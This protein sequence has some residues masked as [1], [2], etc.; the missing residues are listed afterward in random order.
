MFFFFLFL[1]SFDIE[2]LTVFIWYTHTQ[3]FM[4]QR[5]LLSAL[6]CMH[7]QSSACQWVSLVSF[8]VCSTWKSNIWLWFSAHKARPVKWMRMGL[9]SFTE[10]PP[11]T[12]TW[13]ESFVNKWV[14]GCYLAHNPISAMYQLEF[15]STCWSQVD[16]CFKLSNGLI[17]VVT[18]NWLCCSQF[19]RVK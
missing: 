2:Q 16:I 10:I 17:S 13:H 19:F 7:T 9:W 14:V 5:G 18:N 1:T 6:F 3:V 15:H 4:H 12:V 11:Y 8:N